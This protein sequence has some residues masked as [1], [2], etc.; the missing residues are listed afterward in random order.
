[1]GSAAWV[2][3]G[4][5]ILLLSALAAETARADDPPATCGAW[6]VEYVLAASVQL[7]DTVMGA[8]DGV[9]KIGPG[10]LVLRVESQGDKL[11]GH[12]R[13]LSYDMRDGFTV[14]AKALFWQT[15]V[16]NN[17]HTT[18][19]P[20]AAGTIAQGTLGERTLRWDTPI[21]G[22]HTDGT[23]TCEGSFCGKFGAP[24]EGTSDVHYP[25]HLV[26]FSPFEFDVEK[27]TFT[28]GYSIVSK[29]ES[30]RQTSRISLAG[31]EARRT[32]VAK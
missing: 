14:N 2:A 12:V 4:S 10:R 20:D 16:T 13:M 30:P 3:S 6:D 15:V 26:T 27:K 32:C 25:P 11:A 22:L 21:N 9:H 17:T 31:R 24:A 8:G 7:S 5:A 23:L 29:S 19:N 1:M 18:A 28:M